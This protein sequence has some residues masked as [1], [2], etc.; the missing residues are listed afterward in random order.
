MKCCLLNRQR[1]WWYCYRPEG[2]AIQANS[3]LPTEEDLVAHYLEQQQL[4]K[5]RKYEAG[6]EAMVS[7]TAGEDSDVY[8]PRDPIDALN[9][10]ER[11][12]DESLEDTPEIDQGF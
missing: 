5:E 2:L 7:P 3:E 11:E 10:D 4:E 9:D 12:Y 8:M 1:L 6:V